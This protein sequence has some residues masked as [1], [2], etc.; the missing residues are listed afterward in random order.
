[1]P[2]SLRRSPP[3]RFGQAQSIG[4][5]ATAALIVLVATSVL[6]GS[7]NRQF[8]SQERATV[9]SKLST[10]RAKLEGYINSQ[11][12]LAESLA[13]YVAANPQVTQAEF[14][15][16]GTVLLEKNSGIRS[17][18]LA[19]NS[20]ISHIYPLRGNE[21]ALGLNLVA[22]PEQRA[23]VERA[24]QQKRS[25][26]AGPVKLVQGGVAFINRTPAFVVDQPGLNSSPTYW[27][28]ASVVVDEMAIYEAADLPKVSQQLALTIRGK[29]GLGE[30]GDVFWG[31][32]QVFQQDPVL[33]EV[34][35]PNGT[36]QLAATPR[37]GWRDRSPIAGVIWL[38]GGAL[39]I[40]VGAVV[41]KLMGEPTRLQRAVDQA[42][43]ELQTALQDL[44]QE[45][46]NR[47]QV[48][49]ALSNSQLAL[50]KTQAELEIAHRL[51]KML[52][53][54]KSELAAIE[55]LEI[56]SF[57]A[58]AA[59]VSGDYYDVICQGDHIKIGIGD[60]AGH[61]LE[62]G[63]LM[64]MIQM[65]ARTL[66][67]ACEH[68]SARFLNTINRA[69]YENLQR[70]NLHKHATLA[71]LDYQ[72]GRLCLTGQH[73]EVIVVRSSGT[74]ERFDTMDLGF[75][76]GI[77]PDIAHWVQK[78]TL[79][80]KTGDVVVLYTDGI[81]EAQGDRQMAYG[82]ERLCWVTCQ[83]R[84]RPASEIV[85]A[86]VADLRSHLNQQQPED[87]MTLLVLKQR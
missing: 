51:H 25:T 50:T 43:V 87:D 11:L 79:E 71:L 60:V 57:T 86:I 47:Q 22:K 62:S 38:L 73:E 63:L 17:V 40:G 20:V 7:E 19:K 26:I 29:D 21:L 4:A 18:N 8:R 33:V 76:I 53:P 52:L 16:M 36:W 5:A 14:A 58:A 41:W 35:I 2:T 30:R 31:Q 74:I 84:D 82:V 78:A 64:L 12:L 70:M 83:Q 9:L 39:S 77:E 69:I 13:A 49:A 85:A 10:V 56:A 28:L 23:A 61:G 1:M 3:L 6:V 44:R 32:A 81:T 42:T 80:L 67:A 66:L 45:M 34:A 24:I 59:E 54:P 68:N 72:G 37:S 75:P 46:D 15:R 48:E 65:A 55:P 27:G